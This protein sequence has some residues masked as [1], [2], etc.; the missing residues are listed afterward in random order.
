MRYRG[1][2]DVDGSCIPWMEVALWTVNGISLACYPYP[3]GNSQNKFRWSSETHVERSKMFVRF[4]KS[5]SKMFTPR[6]SGSD[7]F[8]HPL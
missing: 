7:S 1:E 6:G 3:H 2:A 4:N 8:Q 5:R